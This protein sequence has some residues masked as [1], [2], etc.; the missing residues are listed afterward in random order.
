MR[1]WV[2]SGEEEEEEGGRELGKGK[3]E[4][5]KDGKGTKEGQARKRRLRRRRRRKGTVVVNVDVPGFRDDDALPTYLAEMIREGIV[6]GGGEVEER[7]GIRG[8]FAWK[9]YVDVSFAL[10][11]LLLRAF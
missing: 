7:L 9:L 11:F 6:G 5:F 3:G 4:R 8:R 10:L 2:G 1:G